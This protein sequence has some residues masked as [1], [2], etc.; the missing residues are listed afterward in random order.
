MDP[1]LTI[2]DQRVLSHEEG[3]MTRDEGFDYR[4]K[5][6]IK[7]TRVKLRHTLQTTRG[8]PDSYSASELKQLAKDLDIKI[9]GLTS[10]TAM[11]E[12]ILRTW[13]K[14]LNRTR[15]LSILNWFE[16]NERNST[17]F[18][19]DLISSSGRSSRLSVEIGRRIGLIRSTRLSVEIGRSVLFD[20]IDSTISWNWK[21]RPVRLDRPDYPLKLE[22]ASCSTRSTRLSV[23]IGR[24]IG[25]ICSTRSTRLSVEIGRSVLFDSTRSTASQN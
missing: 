25:L 20:S 17:Y 2:N 9:T 5:K 15:R 12:H 19:D 4:R 24:R 22:E 10:R 16:L 7:E 18:P 1:E 23:E 13:M 8:G 6:M 14:Y 3:S 21:K 11:A